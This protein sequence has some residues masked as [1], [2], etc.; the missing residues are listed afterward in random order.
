MNQ[1]LQHA[2]WPTA[3]RRRTLLMP[4]EASPPGN[5]IV[6]VEQCRVN[7][8]ITRLFQLIS[9]DPV[10]ASRELIRRLAADVDR[11][12]EE[13]AVT[14]PR[15]GLHLRHTDGLRL[16]YAEQTFSIPDPTALVWRRQTVPDEDG[17]GEEDPISL[18]AETWDGQ[19]TLRWDLRGGH[20]R[21]RITLDPERLVRLAV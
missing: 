20:V 6:E 4:G 17:G 8:S 2:L 1:K 15:R 16:A 12:T 9:R 7:L 5:V 3:D 21:R 18:E 10:T 13:R 11:W 14:D 19:L